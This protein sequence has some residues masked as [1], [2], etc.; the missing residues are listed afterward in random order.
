MILQCMFD[1][2]SAVV[3]TI[4]QSD[5]SA[6]ECFLQKGRDDETMAYWQQDGAFQ[7]FQQFQLL[8]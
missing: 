7:Q 6:D 3:D 8:S 1:L 4:L 2:P 5:N